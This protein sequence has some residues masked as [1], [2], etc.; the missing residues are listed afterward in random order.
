MHSL[1]L[2]VKSSELDQWLLNFWAPDTFAILKITEN[3]K[4]LFREGNGNP[5]QYSCLENPMDRGAWWAAVHGVSKSQTRLSDLTF[6]FHFH[7][8]EKAMATHSSVL[9]WR[10]PGM[11]EAWGAAVYGVAQS[12]T[13]LKRLSSSSRQLLCGLCVLCCAKSLQSCLTLCDP[14]ECS[15]PGSSVHGVLQARILEWVAMPPSRRSSWRGDW[16]CFSFVSCFGRQFLPLVPPG[17][18]EMATHSS[19]L[20]YRILWTE[21]PGGLLSIGS[22]RVGHNWSDLAAAA[23]PPGKLLC[24]LYLLIFTALEMI[25]LRKF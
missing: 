16:T 7:A 8:L 15:P 17:E 19:I 3:L 14:M 2:E 13:G 21:E 24:G 20:A 23:M 11:E 18:K 4:K 10:I 25:R 5:L 22:H 6:T 1:D 12:Q 9:A